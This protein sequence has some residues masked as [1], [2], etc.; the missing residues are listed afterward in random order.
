MYIKKYNLLKIKFIF[1]NSQKT[2]HKADLNIITTT[3]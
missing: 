3:E 1:A 2:D